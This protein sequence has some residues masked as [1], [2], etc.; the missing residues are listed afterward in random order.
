MKILE[1]VDEVAP[2]L[3]SVKEPQF[4]V[5]ATDKIKYTAFALGIFLVCCQIPLYGVT[6]LNS[7]DPFQLI[8]MILASNRGT[9]MELGISPIITSGLVLQLIKGSKLISIDL[10]L[11]ADRDR[12]QALT[13]LTALV[14]TFAEAIAYTWSG[15][16]GP[17][18]IIT[19][20]IIVLQLC[21]SGV[22][23]ILLDDLLTKEYGFGSGISLFIASNVCERIVWTTISPYTY[24]TGRGTEFEGSVVAFVHLM[25]TRENKLMALQE[26]LF[27]SNLP[28]LMSLF[29]TFAIFCLVV[30][31]HGWKV[32]VKMTHAKN[33]GAVQAHEIKLFYTNS[34]P[35]MLQMALVTNITF[36]SQQLYKRYGNSLLIQMLGKWKRG[37]RGPDTIPVSG[38]AYFVT[39]PDGIT[40]IWNDFGHF[41]IYCI[42]VLTVCAIFSK[43]WVEIS[44]TS[45][46]DIAQ[47][48]TENK[49]LVASRSHG[50][51]NN[52]KQ[53]M[54]NALNEYIPT[55]A[56]FGG[57]CLGVLCI[58][59]DVLGAIGGGQGI[60]ICVSIIY[61]YWKELQKDQT[62]KKMV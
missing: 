32:S 20:T 27:R 36:F 61:D 15:M 54:Q 28:N 11:K 37:P 10:S 45:A 7:G 56:A 55:A 21:A 46:R 9:L 18:G 17:V 26:A 57:I 52:P 13:K 30:Y 50:S 48:Y 12:Y 24:N 41:V 47:R 43:T 2:F 1:L 44:G 39:P 49:W 6:N 59:A 31:V 53:A 16:Y 14:I 5:S 42:F 35:I 51:A 58:L 19:G 4:A 29:G 23:V 8:R 40:A 33:R 62:Y 22:A 60:M 25:L 38:L 3:P 34:M